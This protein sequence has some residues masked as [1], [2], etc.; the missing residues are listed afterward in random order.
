MIQNVVA[1]NNMAMQQNMA[2]VIQAIQQSNQ[3][4]TEALATML[5][6]LTKPKAVVRDANGKII[7]VQ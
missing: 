6:Q 3:Q 4:Q 5:A 2:S 1:E 7:G